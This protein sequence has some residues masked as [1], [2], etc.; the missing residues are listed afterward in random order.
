MLAAA[1]AGFVIALLSDILLD[2]ST[3]PL[4]PGSPLLQNTFSFIVK[5]VVSINHFLPLYVLLFT[6]Y[7]SNVSYDKKLKILLPLDR[8][9]LPFLQ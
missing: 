9:R 5:I 4:H 2:T 8:V 1:Q 6:H 7:I 3:P